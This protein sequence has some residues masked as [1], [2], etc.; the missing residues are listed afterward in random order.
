MKTK[1]ACISLLLT[2]VLLMGM[3]LPAQAGP[4]SDYSMEK[5]LLSTAEGSGIVAHG[6]TEGFTTIVCEQQGFSTLIRNDYKAVWTDQGLFIDLDAQDILPGIVIYRYYN[7]ASDPEVHLQ[8]VVTPL[9]KRN[10]GSALTG[11]SD[12]FWF[13]FDGYHFPAVSYNIESEYGRYQYLRAVIREGNDLID[14]GAAFYEEDR[15]ET[16]DALQTAIENFEF[17]EVAAEPKKETERPDVVPTTSQGED[18][19]EITPSEVSQVKFASY[20]DSDGWFSMMLPEGWVLEKGLRLNGEN[21]QMSLVDYSITV[22]DPENPDRMVY[23]NLCTIG[24]LKT[25][26]ARNWYQEHDPGSMFADDPVVPEISTWGV[27]KGLENVYDYTDFDLIRNLGSDGFGEDVLL[28]NCTSSLTGKKLKGFFSARPFD[29]PYYMMEYPTDIWNIQEIDAG[30]LM[31]QDVAMEMAPEEEF[32]DWLP[33]LDYILCSIRFTDD[34][35]YYR[36]REWSMIIK[37]YDYVMH[38]ADVIGDM[39]MDTWENA[40]HSSDVASQKYS[41]ATMGYER[42]LDTETG[43]YYKAELGFFDWYDGER[44]VPVDTDEAYLTPVS[45]TINWK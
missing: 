22:Y 18:G 23:L 35:N 13:D 7:D 27:F 1:K 29:I 8:N 6:P 28:A 34:F 42:V 10:F 37:N 17:R 40:E 21:D 5:G 26:A 41:D 31:V 33:V 36:Q 19:I 15:T 2:T 38:T 32:Y 44:Y 16:M 39:I 11:Y 24:F 25:E 45:G 4:L 20:V 14:Y 9:M 12:L 3:V 43:E 30:Y